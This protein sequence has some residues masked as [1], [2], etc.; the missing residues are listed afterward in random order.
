MR[1]AT[2]SP[3]IWT[4]EF[5]ISSARPSAKWAWS[6]AG[7]QV[8]E[9]QHGHGRHGAGRLQRG[10]RPGAARAGGH[11]QAPSAT[12]TAA[13]AG[14]QRRDRRRAGRRRS[15]DSPRL[16]R[17]REGEGL[18]AATTSPASRYRST[19]SLASMRA[20][21]P[22]G[23]RGLGDVEHRRGARTRDRAPLVVGEGRLTGEHPVEHTPSAKTSVR[24][25]S[26]APR[27]CSGAMKA[28]VPP[29][30]LRRPN[31]WAIPRS[32]SFTWPSSQRKTLAED[33][34]RWTMPARVGVRRPRATSTVTR[35]ASARRQRPRGEP[36][37]RG[38]RR[39]GA[40]GRGTG[41]TRIAPRRTG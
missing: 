36:L 29:S 26:G 22:A 37:R 34:S 15:P 20:T 6:W 21:I 12:S 31:A 23:A 7:A 18:S 40:R 2:R 24:S 13:A 33:R 28:G 1:P 25:S 4:S 35:M 38:S 14:A 32:S 10:G 27:H 19:G 39:G 5:R 11:A 9:R 3:S 41:R 16:P 30:T 17:R 8:G